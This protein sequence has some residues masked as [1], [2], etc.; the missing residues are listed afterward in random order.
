I[1]AALH[2][3]VTDSNRQP[4]DELDEILDIGG[5][6]WRVADDGKSL[7][8]RIDP[9]A[10]EAARVAM[11]PRGASSDE[12]RKAWQAVY[13]RNPNPSDAWDHAIKAT[14]AVLIPIVVPSQAKP[15]LGHVIGQLNSNGGAWKL[16]LPGK[17]H[18]HDISPLVSMLN[19]LWPNPD[20]HA[21]NTS[22]EP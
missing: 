10:K 19:L 1:D 21:N 7:E 5:S 8:R 18:D 17:N 13:G 9:V 4:A 6:A 12:L 3:K 20:R 14:E 11:N 2:A 15:T 22:R 16:V